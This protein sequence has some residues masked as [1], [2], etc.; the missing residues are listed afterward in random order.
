MYFQ[1]KDSIGRKSDGSRDRQ[2]D[3]GKAD[4]PI[5]TDYTD[6]ELENDVECFGCRF[7]LGSQKLNVAI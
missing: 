4:P 1:G 7:I 2:T 6:Y 5:L 3:T